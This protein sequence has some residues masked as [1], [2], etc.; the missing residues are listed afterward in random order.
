MLPSWY[1]NYKEKIDESINYYLDNYFNNDY[2]NNLSS[3]KEACYYAVKWWKK[4]RAI[5]ALEFY[6]I[7]ANKNLSDIDINDDILKLC[8]WIE[9]IHAYSLV[10]DDLPCMD[11]DEYRRWELTVWKKY[12]EDFWVLIWDLLNTLA[13]ELF[14]SVNSKYGLEIVKIIS[15]STWFYGMIWGQVL[16][17]YYEKN[18]IDDIYNLENVH[19][20]KT[21]ALI[22]ASVLCWALLWWDKD[23]LKYSSFAKN[24]WLAFQIK[25]DILDVEGTLEETWKSVWWEKK[26]FVYFMWIDKTK[27]YLDDLLEASREIVKDSNSEKLNFII[28]YIWNRNK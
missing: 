8:A 23:Y 12:W 3:F 26:W 11:N 20:L 4:L 21:W 9:L 7:V 1:N 13:Y 17:L 24:I 18:N 5:L 28:D 19:N 27:K 15:R 16:D 6:L 2:D 14:S 25:D 22:E 10:H